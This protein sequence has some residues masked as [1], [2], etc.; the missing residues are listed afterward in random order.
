MKNLKNNIIVI[1]I[2]LIVIVVRIVMY[3]NIFST[4]GGDS[5]EFLLIARRIIDFEN[6][7]EGVKRLP[8]FPVTLLPSY[9]FNVDGIWWGRFVNSIFSGLSVYYLFLILNK[10]KLSKFLNYLSLILFSFSQVY[11]FYSLRPLSSSLFVF[12]FLASIYYA[13]SNGKKHTYYVFILLGLLSMTRHEGFV[14][15]F[16]V[17]IY[18]LFKFRKNLKKLIIPVILYLIIVGPYFINNI[19]NHNNVFYLSYLSDGGG[20]YSP[21]NYDDLKNNLKIMNNSFYSL[22]GNIKVLKSNL[23]LVHITYISSLFFILIGFLRFLKIISK[24]KILILSLIISQLGISLWLQPSGRYIQ[25]VV[26][27]FSYFLILGISLVSKFY[28][29]VI[30]TII[31]LTTSIIT[32]NKK[33]DEFN[34]DTRKQKEYTDQVLFLKEKTGI[35][36]IEPDR[37]YTFSY[38]AQYYLGYNRVY[39][40]GDDYLGRNIIPKDPKMQLEELLSNNVNY[41]LDSEKFDDFTILKDNRISKKIK[42]VSTGIYE[43]IK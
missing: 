21:K 13:I 42:L 24:E 22:W 34:F 11:L 6:P 10:F 17:L 28:L 9:L 19:I 2:A 7:F 3:S 5:F 1:L 38:I 12:L 8:V 20:L 39:F 30:M 14:V 36:A 35:V 23:K 15:S 18:F 32:V 25:Q 27:F 29:P 41:V 16:I 31:L 33:I 4:S 40:L 26:P 37:D 43:I